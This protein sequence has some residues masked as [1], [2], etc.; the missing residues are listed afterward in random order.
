MLETAM[1]LLSYGISS[2]KECIIMHFGQAYTDR[3]Y[4][5]TEMNKVH[6]KCLNLSHIRRYGPLLLLVMARGYC[7]AELTHLCA[8]GRWV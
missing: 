3:V 4:N 7:R 5:Y 6:V 2:H 1:D 8:S